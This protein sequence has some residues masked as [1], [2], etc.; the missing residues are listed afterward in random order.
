MATDKPA[1]AE[2]RRVMRAIYL[3]SRLVG[4]PLGR[5]QQNVHLVA[6]NHCLDVSPLLLVIGIDGDGAQAHPLRRHNLVAHQRYKWRDQ[7]GG[8]STLFPQ[9]LGGDEIDET[10]APSGLRYRAGGSVTAWDPGKY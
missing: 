5:D 3:F 8:A 1:K 4:Q 10:L 7:Q 2:P 6:L 9:Q